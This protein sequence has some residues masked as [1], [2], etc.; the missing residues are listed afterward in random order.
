M[1]I[2]RIYCVDESIH[3]CYIGSTNNIHNRLI[4]HKSACNNKKHVGYNCKLYQFIRAHGGFDNWLCETID[5][6]DCGDGDKYEIEQKY[7][8]L[9][10]PELNSYKSY[11]TEEGRK[12]YKKQY[13]IKNKEKQKQYNKEYRA[14]N[15][16]YYKQYYKQY[17]K[18]YYAKNKK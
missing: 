17:H 9:Y 15:K 4:T 13:R 5:E 16:E 18:K 2:Y 8:N 14:K 3:E 1:I 7:I 11:S 10:E 12:E 6:W